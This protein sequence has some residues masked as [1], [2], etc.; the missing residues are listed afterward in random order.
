MISQAEQGSATAT[1]PPG[2]RAIAG[3]FVTRFNGQSFQGNVVYESRRVRQRK[4]RTSANHTSG[5][6]P[7][8]LTSIAYCGDS[9]R[10]T[11]RSSTTTLDGS[12]NPVGGARAT[13]PR[14]RRVVSGGFKSSTLPFDSGGFSGAFPRSSRRAAHSRRTWKASGVVRTSQTFRFKAYAYCA[15][16]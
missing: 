9:P 2:E 6:P 15:R 10:L 4:W 5:G 8:R 16:R 14:G 7:T 11:K 1:C 12:T 3:G 13:C